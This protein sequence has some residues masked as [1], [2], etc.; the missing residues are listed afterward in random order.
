MSCRTPMIDWALKERFVQVLRAHGGTQ[1]QILADTRHHMHAP[2]ER[3]VRYWLN[4]A[5][6]TL[7]NGYHWDALVS[8]YGHSILTE[9]YLTKKD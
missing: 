7:P 2:S 4:T 3:T 8:A 1:A 9:T 5:E 6:T